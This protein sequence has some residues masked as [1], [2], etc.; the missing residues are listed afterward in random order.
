VIRTFIRSPSRSLA[1]RS[2][3]S[4]GKCSRRCRRIPSR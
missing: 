4:W 2:R 1:T 3:S